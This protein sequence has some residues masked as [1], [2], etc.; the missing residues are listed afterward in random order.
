MLNRYSTTKMRDLWSLQY[1]FSVWEKIELGACE[2]WFN[3]GKI[4]QNDWDAIQKKTSFNVER[5]QE[6]ESEIH[7]D[8]L[9]FLTNMAENIGTSSRYVHFGLTSSDVVDTATSCIIIE[10]SKLIIS[11]CKT[12]LNNLHKQAEQHKN[13]IVVGRTHGIHAEP[14]TLGIKLL[15]FYAEGFRNYTRLVDAFNEIAYGK[16]SGAVGTYSQVPTDLEKFVLEKLSLQPEPIST[17]VIPRDRHANLL[18]AIALAGQGLARLAQEIRLLQKTESGE[19][20]EPFQAHQKGSS[21]MPHKKNPILCER[22]CGL[23]RILTGYASSGM[24]NVLLWHERDISHSSAERILFPDALSLIEYMYIKLDFVIRNL[25]V[26]ERNSK[27]VLN[28]TRGLIYS[29]R[30]LLLI[31]EELQITREKAYDIVQSLAMQ[32]WDD[33]KNTYFPDQ[34]R[35]HPALS[36]ISEKQWDKVF[37]AKDFLT[38]IDHIFQSVNDSYCK[39]F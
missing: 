19:V 34:L 10:S 31:T 25:Y 14:T 22:I 4:P 24:D 26:S 28:K 12:F 13:V 5:I 35:Q 18:N 16:I 1:K 27:E 37:D 11:A 39:S 33:P 38:N 6:I 7:H 30:A 29:S 3:Q 32:V 21:A 36:Q 8:V 2:Y 20:Q 15:G 23:A 9:A 17:Q